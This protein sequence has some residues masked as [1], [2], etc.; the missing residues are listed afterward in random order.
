MLS[1]IW[2]FGEG[3][4]QKMGPTLCIQKKKTKTS[5]IITR[6][7]RHIN[8]PFHPNK[9]WPNGKKRKQEKTK[10]KTSVSQ[11]KQK[12]IMNSD[13]QNQSTI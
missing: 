7:D 1:K 2:E 5:K 9:G 8:H 11:L 6:M 4:N 12:N 3:Y 10:Q 13:D